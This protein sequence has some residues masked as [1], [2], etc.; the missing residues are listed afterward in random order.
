MTYLQRRK[1]AFVVQFKIQA[2]EVFD[3][4]KFK[5]KEEKVLTRAHCLEESYED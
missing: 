1:N 2:P 4:K 3:L 5:K